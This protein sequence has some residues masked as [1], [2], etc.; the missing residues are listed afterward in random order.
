MAIR[1][2]LAP[3]SWES[4]M[5]GFAFPEGRREEVE[6]DKEECAL[7]TAPGKPSPC[8]LKAILHPQ[9]PQICAPPSPPHSSLPTACLLPATEL[10]LPAQL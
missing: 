8:P 6:G 1:V 2:A 7:P 10:N 4:L 3:E 5:W 9:P